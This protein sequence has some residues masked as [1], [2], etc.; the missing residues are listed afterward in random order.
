MLPNPHDHKGAERTDYET[1]S[2]ASIPTKEV[3]QL[4]AQPG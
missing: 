4:Q 3:E 2:K 1:R